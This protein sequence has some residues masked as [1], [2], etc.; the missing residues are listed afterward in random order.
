MTLNLHQI[1][2]SL[3]RNDFNVRQNLTDEE[4]AEFDKNV[5]WMIPQWMASAKSEHAH[6]NAV[7]MFDEFCNPGWGSFYNHPELQA[8]LL[9]CMGMGPTNHQF[10]KRGKRST[11]ITD[12]FGMLQ[13]YYEDIRREEVA[14]WCLNTNIESLTNHM[15]DLGIDTDSRKKIVDQWKKLRPSNA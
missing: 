5:S 9:A 10:P 4:R 1:L 3:D 12:L 11:A 6:A 7:M 14:L 8:K 15:D 2:D 13:T